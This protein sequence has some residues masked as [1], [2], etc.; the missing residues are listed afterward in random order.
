MQLHRLPRTAICGWLRATRL[1]LNAVEAI[2]RR[3]PHDVEWAP[4]ITFDSFEATVKQLAGS[5]LHDAELVQEGEAQYRRVAQRR[6]T[7][8]TDP[9]RRR[10]KAT[11][12]ETRKA[13]RKTTSSDTAKS[14][15]KAPTTKRKAA[16]APSRA[17]RTAKRPAAKKS[18]RRKAVA[19]QRRVTK[20]AKRR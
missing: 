8:A 2:V 13:K 3:G 14:Q 20:T 19:A 15:A 10:G 7:V 5:F 16:K 17:A 12:G 18:V 9:V 11:A 6:K 1:P 4:A